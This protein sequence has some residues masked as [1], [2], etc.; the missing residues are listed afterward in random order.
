M[1][2][3]NTYTQQ[4]IESNISKLSD[5]I[6]SLKKERTELSQNIN[7]LKKQVAYWED[8]QLTQYKMF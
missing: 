1:K 5:N 6:E 7:A 4:E 3:S 2:E 8:M